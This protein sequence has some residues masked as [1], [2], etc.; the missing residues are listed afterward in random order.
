[1]PA[2]KNGI[3]R[4]TNVVA[5]TAGASALVCSVCCAVPL[6]IPAIALTTTGAAVAAFAGVYQWAMYISL[7]LAGIGWGWL[8]WQTVR[9]R[10]L[11]AASRLRAIG[12]STLVVGASLAWPHIER[13][14]RA[15]FRA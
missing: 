14:I 12:V 5:G 8:A 9:A 10:R 7:A 1:M 11:P 15:A 4:P 3:A 6:A 2:S 13:A